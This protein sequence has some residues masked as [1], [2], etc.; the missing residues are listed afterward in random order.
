MLITSTGHTVNTFLNK[1]ALEVV[2]ELK[3][4]I[5]EGLTVVF[6]K[7]MNDAFGRIPTEF[8]LEREAPTN[9]TTT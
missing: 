9:T 7:V 1:N 6:K 3:E 5:G 4:N 2:D 8:W